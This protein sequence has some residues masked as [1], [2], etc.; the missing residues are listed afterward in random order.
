MIFHENYATRPTIWLKGMTVLVLLVNLLLAGCELREPEEVLPSPARPQPTQ[1]TILDTPT[2]PPDEEVPDTALTPQPTGLPEVVVHDQPTV[3]D[4]VTITLV[5]SP[6]AGWVVVYAEEAGDPGPVIGF[7]SVMEGINRDVQVDIDPERVSETLFAGLHEDA[8]VIGAFEF[9]G[10]DE[11]IE[12]NDQPLVVPFQVQQHLAEE[13]IIFEPVVGLDLVGDGFTAPVV[14]VSPPDETGRLFVADQIGEIM[15]ITPEGERVNEPFL[16]LSPRI[17]SLRQTFDE[18]GLL[19][20]AFHPNFMENG[21]FFVYYSAPLREGGPSGWDHTSHI[22]EFR[23]SAEDPNRADP[24]SESIILQV[25]QPQFNHNGGGLTFGSDGYLYISLGDGGGAGDRGVGHPPLGN[26]QDLDTLH[27]SILRIDVDT[28]EPYRI[29][30]DNPQVGTEGGDE[31]YA[32]GLRNPYRISFDAA[33]QHELFAADA[34]QD[35]WEAVYLIQPGGNYGWNIR[36]GSHCFNPQ[37]P[38]NPPSGCPDTGPRGEPLL[39]PIIEYPH[40]NQPDGLGIAPIGGFIYRG[41]ALPSFQGRYV[42]GDWTRSF[43]N[44]DGSLFV[45]TRPNPESEMWLLEELRIATTET[46]RVGGYVL[47]FGQ[48]NHHDLYVLTTQF[49]GPTGTSGQVWRII[50]AN[51]G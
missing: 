18:R 24:D 16:D 17:V 28:E 31:I 7:S 20:M 42:F 33:G 49:S 41:E 29:P 26:A 30:M 44:P 23:V 2:P 45:A 25:D 21:R 50:P 51:D 35:L 34:G 43:V 22:S 37:S 27:G 46:G 14:L 39:D 15:I 10:P 48:D 32:Y 1:P 36:E 11:L 12:I 6:G 3:N 9:P 5:F 13:T 19:G 4:T 47:G 38:L 8:G 40:I